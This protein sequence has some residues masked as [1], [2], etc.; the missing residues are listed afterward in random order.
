MN[1]SERDELLIRMDERQQ[2]MGTVVSE[3][4]DE[5]KAHNKD[6][7]GLINKRLSS[8]SRKINW[9]VGIGTGVVAAFGFIKLVIARM[10]E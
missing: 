8:H 7:H 3:I 5:S 4:R 10:K 9:M 1:E 6:T 2:Q